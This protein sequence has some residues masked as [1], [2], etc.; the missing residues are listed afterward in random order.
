VALSGRRKEK[1]SFG[2]FRKK[3]K[4]M[5]VREDGGGNINIRGKHR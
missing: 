5:D 3:S 2:V 1:A 4:I